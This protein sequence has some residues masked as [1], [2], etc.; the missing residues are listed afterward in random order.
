MIYRLILIG[1]IVI[2]NFSKMKGQ[3]ALS[4]SESFSHNLLFDLKG[5]Q[6]KVGISFTT[7]KHFFFEVRGYT[8]FLNGDKNSVDIS[9]TKNYWSI[10]DF[11]EN[12][13]SN[14]NKITLST[15]PFSNTYASMKKDIGA[16][17]LFGYR[18]GIGKKFSI[19]IA[20]I[21]GTRRVSLHKLVENKT[22]TIIPLPLDPVINSNVPI[23]VIYPRHLLLSYSDNYTGVDILLSWY[24]KEN[25]SFGLHY[26]YLESF[27]SAGGDMLIGIKTIKFLK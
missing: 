12:F 4:F 11:P 18:I 19:D 5:V 24:P 17:I 9:Q 21:F 13:P 1:L 8:S 15:S 10:D 14:I 7:K 2:I 6:S 22:F 25:I 26:E 23:D 27:N 16:E 3:T 20:S